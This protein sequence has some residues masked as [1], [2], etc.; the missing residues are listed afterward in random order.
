MF[1]FAIEADASR[2]EQKTRIDSLKELLDEGKIDSARVIHLN[3]IACE[4]R[5]TNLDSAILVTVQALLVAE[6]INWSKGIAISLGNLG[7]YHRTKADYPKALDY[8]FRALKIDKALNDKKGMSARYSNIGIV[9]EYQGDYPMA[10][11]YYLQ[12]M[13]LAEQLGD[14]REI[15]GA[16]NNIGVIYQMQEN[17]PEA[18]KYYFISLKMHRETGNDYGM[19]ALYNN[20]GG[21]Y[22]LQGNYEKA[23]KEHGAALELSKKIGDKNVI[24]ASYNNMGILYDDLGKYDEALLS[25]FE[26]LKIREETGDEEGIATSYINI[27]AVELRLG[28]LEDSKKYYDL[29][30]SRSMIIG[31]RDDIRESYGGLARVDSMLGD[32]MLKSGKWKEAAEYY[33]SA[34]SNYRLCVIYKDSLLSDESVQKTMQLQMTY[35]FDKKAVAIK[36]EHEKENALE[37]VE[38][39]RQRVLLY[40]VLIGLVL[41]GVFIFFIYSSLQV[42]RRQKVLIEAQKQLVEKSDHEKE[43]LLKEIHHRV[44]NNLQII[45]SLLS[46]QSNNIKDPS[47]LSVVKQAQVRVRSMSLVHQKL[48]QAANFSEIDFGEYLEQLSSYISEMYHDGP[49]EIACNINTQVRHFNIDTATPLGLIIT[50][51]LSNSYKY[52]FKAR[53]EGK[54]DI[55]ITR[56]E[57]GEFLLIYSDNG[58]GLPPGIVFEDSATLGLELVNLLT[59]QL[60]GTVKTFNR[61]GAVFEIR[62]KGAKAET[63]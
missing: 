34:F 54:I 42:T 3:A 45:S 53:E 14:K 28:H 9:F 46:L 11:N 50:E 15:A 63:H 19:A 23:L 39:K 57:G 38:I 17:Y 21:I 59:K 55:S 22:Q 33:K 51:L 2:A 40:S 27:G 52:A 37:A 24:A 48:Y 1:G 26:G 18:L 31:N 5:N 29:A 25:L 16:Y 41:M 20:I 30:L 58:I 13:K 47:T 44:K 32:R 7:V 43:V 49:G 36:A 62:F 60:R 6:K 56:D 12:G 8:F 35:D 10:L 61:N 4:V